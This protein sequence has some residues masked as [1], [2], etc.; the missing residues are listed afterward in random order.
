M[1]IIIGLSVYYYY[2]YYDLRIGLDIGAI[3]AYSIM[4]EYRL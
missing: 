4:L 3:T 1:S 2:Y